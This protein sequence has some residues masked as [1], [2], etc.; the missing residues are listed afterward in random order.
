LNPAVGIERAYL[1]LQDGDYEA[2]ITLFQEALEVEDATAGQQLLLPLARAYFGAGRYGELVALWTPS[3]LEALATADRAVALGLMARSFDALGEWKEAISAYE[4][5]LELDD[6]AAY[7]VRLR[8]AK[9]YESL[10]EPEKAVQQLQEIDPTDLGPPAKAEILERL[11]GLLTQLEDHEGALAAYDQILS[12]AKV[13]YYRSLILQR[14]GQL[15]LEMGRQDEGVAVLHEPLQEYPHT[16]GAY[17]ALLALD[18]IEAAE[19]TLLLRG[20]VLYHAGQYVHSIQTLEAYR[21]A[22]PHGF[23]ST[24]H[25]YAGLAYHALGRYEEAIEGFDVVI[26]HFPWS[27]VVG[28]AWMAKAR[29]LAAL[30]EQPSELY[31]EFASRYPGHPQ[32]R[33]ALWRAALGLQ[34]QGDWEQAGKFHGALRR[35]YAD[36]SRAEEAG[37]REALAAYALGDYD[38]ARD[39]WEQSLPDIPSAT[40]A[41]QDGSARERARALTWMGLASARAGEVESARASWNEAASLAPESYYSL[42]ARDLM[43]GDSLQLPL[44]AAA[45]IPEFDLSEEDWQ[46]IYEWIQ[47]WAQSD[48]HMEGPIEDQALVRRAK[49][50]WELDWHDEAMDTYRL[51]RDE[52]TDDPQATLALAEHS[53]RNGILAMVI[54]CAER[55]MSLGSSADADEPPGALLRLAY[56]TAYGH[57]VKAEAT[58]RDIDPLLFLALIRQES[59]FN[60]H[61]TSWAGAMGLA[62]VMPDTGAWIAEKIGPEPYENALLFR[63]VVSVRYGVWYLAG[64][65]D[66]CDRNWLAALAA[67]NAGWKN[68]GEWMGGEPIRDPDLFYETIP[69]A[70]T[71][72]YVRLV[73]ENYR[74]YQRIYR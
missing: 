24:A 29:S 28:D 45:Q 36:D 33:E 1:A 60:P 13:A 61:V 46:Q 62:Q 7:Q 26:R 39:L 37:F 40:P 10:D 23:H 52:I 18:E 3:D 35:E 48:G 67:Y 2:A 16:W 38:R 70:E 54:A 5:Y 25:Y 53:Y 63:P 11:A 27:D 57:L 14:K 47:S 55:L 64:A 73:Y 6:V 17:A 42:R 9:A 43:R 20:E 41:E 4:R 69:L 34:R 44:D 30:G 8:M 15:L 56:P 74:T 12:F 19:I 59:Q 50:L 49:A 32:A 71:K 58:L 21:L 72:A 31:R 22:N 68:V 65:L 51:F 66:V